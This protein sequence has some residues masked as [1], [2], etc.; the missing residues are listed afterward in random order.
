MG[1][2]EARE[3]IEETDDLDELEGFNK[4]FRQQEK[5]CIEVR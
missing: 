1:I 3:S 2:M 5:Q 4:T